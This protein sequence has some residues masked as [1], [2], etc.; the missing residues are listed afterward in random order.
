M[1]QFAEWLDIMKNQ[2][3][4]YANKMSIWTVSNCVTRVWLILTLNLTSTYYCKSCPISE[5]TFMFSTFTRLRTNAGPI[6]QLYSISC[7]PPQI[8]KYWASLRNLV[9]SLLNS[10][11]SIASLLLLLFLFIMIFALL[12]MQVITTFLHLSMVI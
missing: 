1:I 6:T 7:F 5:Y 12:G 10:M 11:K 2:R 9:A 8:T 4:Q 3:L